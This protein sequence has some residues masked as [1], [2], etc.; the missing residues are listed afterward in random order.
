M[1]M[2][3]YEFTQSENKQFLTY[4][5]RLILLSISLLFAGLIMLVQGLIPPENWGDFATGIVLVLMGIALLIPVYNLQNV[6]VTTGND[7]AE[8]MKG[9]T[10]LSRGFTFVIVAAV[11]L[12]VGIGFEYYEIFFG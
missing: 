6:T 11:A 3:E 12:L 1:K 2:S 7:V 9:F 10:I 8:L 5:Q 4:T